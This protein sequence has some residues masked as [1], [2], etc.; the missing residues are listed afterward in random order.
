MSTE[1]KFDLQ[2]R[3]RTSR[4]CAWLGIGLTFLVLSGCANQLP[5]NS[6]QNLAPVDTKTLPTVAEY[7]ARE[8]ELLAKTKQDLWDQVG[9]V[10]EPAPL[11]PVIPAYDPLENKVV[12]V[13]M[14][15][16][17]VGVLLWA[18]ADQLGMNLIM[19]PAVQEITQRA[20]LN[21]TDVTAR[22]VFNHILQAFDLYGEV[23]GHTLFVSKMQEK[24]YT[25]G[26]LATN[27][28]MQ[29][30]DGGNI[31]GSNGGGSSGGSGGGG[32]SGGGGG[33]GSGGSGS[34]AISS[35]FTVSGELISKGNIYMQIEQGL[36]VVLGSATRVE[37]PDQQDKN[38]SSLARKGSVYSLNESTGMLYVRA[39]PS[40]MQAIDKVVG[41]L[42]RVL[43][44]QVQIDVQLIDVQL[45]DA[46]QFGVDWT[47]MREYLVGVIGDAP[48][49]LEAVTRALPAQ[50]EVRL[51]P[52][53]LTI[54]EQL[55]GSTVPRSIG[56][57]YADDDLSVAVNMLRHFGDVTVLS[58]PSV[59]VRNGSPAILSVGT[60]I[61]Y[62]AG[63][64]SRIANPG[65]GAST[66]STNVETD[67]L[68]SGLM[69]GVVPFIHEDGTVELLVHPVQSEVDPTS[70]QLIDTGG[71]TRISLPVTSFKSMTTTL[72]VRDGSMV[73][74]GG[75][76]DQNIS[77][78][79]NGVPVVADIPGLGRLFD[80]SLDSHRA[81][82]LVMVIRVNIL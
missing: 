70:L 64:S 41:T 18:M 31:F 47:L 67:T 11:P 4:T 81:R 49:A 50:G 19:Q 45:S 12:T 54:P 40:Q 78:A 68:F 2:H 76:I 13:R 1:P 22:E 34:S 9:H 77:S 28:D 57:G 17:S 15:D 59:R 38:A 39:R 79:H 43:G 7:V 42:K 29:V 66:I 63:T 35:N 71:G 74:I 58:N 20:T 21:L 60:N 25:L 36:E 8:S 55:I 37:G 3:R 51:P 30:R 48:L 16:A 14:Y 24:V 65:G 26:F 82:E 75:L 61:T 5:R 46:Y 56:F 69:I 53:S 6:T 80:K 32:A 44:R 72:Q 62:L 52:R 33:G 23:H 73:M 10:A 27:M